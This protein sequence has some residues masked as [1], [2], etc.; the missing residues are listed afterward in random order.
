MPVTPFDLWSIYLDAEGDRD[1]AVQAALSDFAATINA[2]ERDM[3]TGYYRHRQPTA[4]T[5]WPFKPVP[6]ALDLPPAD[7]E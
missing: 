3:A 2:R 7:P 6:P 5:S 4:S 1:A